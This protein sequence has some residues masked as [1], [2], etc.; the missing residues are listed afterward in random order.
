MATWWNW[1]TRGTQNAVTP[2]GFGGS[3]PSVATNIMKIHY[4]CSTTS[5]RSACGLGALDLI[6][7]T[8]RVDHV[9]CMHCIKIKIANAKCDLVRAEQELRKWSNILLKVKHYETR[10]R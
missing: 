1:H 7:S 2:Q 9:T 10:Q 4:S 5:F 8:R 3:T 6:R